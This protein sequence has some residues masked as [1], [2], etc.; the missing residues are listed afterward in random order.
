MG[1]LVYLDTFF[2]SCPLNDGVLV[3]ALNIQSINKVGELDIEI[4]MI[5]GASSGHTVTWSYSNSESR[6]SSFDNLR[7]MV[8]QEKIAL[9]KRYGFRSFRG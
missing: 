1:K 2:L 7:D 6:D 8:S 4:S 9:S 3:N 5:P